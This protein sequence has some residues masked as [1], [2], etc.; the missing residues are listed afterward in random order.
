VI[1]K[2]NMSLP[3]KTVIRMIFLTVLL[4]FSGAAGVS[5]AD[6]YHFND[7]GGENYYT[8]IPGPGRAKVRLPLIGEKK[9]KMKWSPAASAYQKDAYEPVIASAGRHFAVDPNLIRAVIKAES[10]YNERA[11]SPKGAL[12][13][14]QL[15]PATA[16]D[17][18][19]TDPF[20]PVANI[21]GG[22]RYL[23]QLLWAFN[24]DFSLALAAYNAGPARVS[25]R[26][27]IP[28]FPETRAYVG[29]VLNLYNN[30]KKRNEI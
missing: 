27:G 4:I 23:S 8:N 25:S 21:H 3:A 16:R 26:S 13:L 19:V 30:L 15:M 17:M 2:G 14:M 29:R 24:G 6:I 10:N 22:V 5:A 9:N 1:C 18:N 7:N 20:D 11:V 12:G 28:H